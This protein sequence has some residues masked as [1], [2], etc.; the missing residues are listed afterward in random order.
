MSNEKVKGFL[1]KFL[2]NE[3]VQKAYIAA[4]GKIHKFNNKAIHL[5]AYDE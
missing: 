5:T 4:H 3:V 2:I 1:D